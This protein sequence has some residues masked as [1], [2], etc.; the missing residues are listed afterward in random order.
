MA[1]VMLLLMMVEN[2][3]GERKWCWYLDNCYGRYRE[4]DDGDAP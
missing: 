4:D 1:M 3:D 2:G